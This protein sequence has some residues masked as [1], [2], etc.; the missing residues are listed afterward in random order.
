MKS[1]D[2]ALSA[3]DPVADAIQVDETAADELFA[4]ADLLEGQPP[5]R[6][7]LSDP[8]ASG[9]DRQALARRLFE[10]RLGTAALSVVTEVAHRPWPSGRTMIDA[11]ERQGV[12]GLL[13]TAN[14]R[15]EL[16]R[17]QEELHR[18]ALVIDG[19]PELSDALRNR[20]RALADR[21]A[22]IVRLLAGRVASVTER[23]ALRAA[24]AR[25]RTV[26]L[27]LTGYLALSAD[28][29]GERVA[30]ITVAR[31]LDA[32][33]VERLRKALEAQVGGP[34]LLQIEVDESVIGGMSVDLGTHVFESTVARRL[35]EVRRL[36]N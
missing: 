17:V 1:R 33:R 14:E 13:R 19:S 32:G 28:L 20:G 34:V 7:S 4:V 21:R 15:G 3:F 16:K 5:L 27:T 31:P 36:L 25:A 6:R 12:R 35:D 2:V 30:R 9:R 22:L 10:G 29:A 18:F 8:S 26:P 11:I 24:A 23:L